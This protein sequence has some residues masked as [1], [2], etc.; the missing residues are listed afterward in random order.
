MSTLQLLHISD[1]HIK[2]DETVDNNFRDLLIAKVKTD[3]SNGFNP[4]IVVVSGDIAFSGKHSEYEKARV[5]FDNLLS[6]MNLPKDRLF[7]VPGNHDVNL[8][9]YRP[10]DVPVYETMDELNRELENEDFR[11]DL[12]KGMDEYFTFVETNYPHIKPLYNRLV[13]FVNCFESSCGK[14]IGLVGLNSAWMERGL[15]Y[16]TP[17]AIGEFQIKKAIEA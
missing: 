11:A 4:E 7:I 16:E 13:P 5:F 15:H 2:N 12:I 14:R 10:Y 8:S 9:K 3:I 17:V 1:L 6:A